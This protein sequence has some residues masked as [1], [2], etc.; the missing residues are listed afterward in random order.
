M[1]ERVVQSSELGL[2]EACHLMPRCFKQT[3]PDENDSFTHLRLSHHLSFTLLSAFSSCENL[4]D[5]VTPILLLLLL[6][7]LHPLSP[8][9]SP[10]SF[11]LPLLR[12]GD[13]D[14]FDRRTPPKLLHHNSPPFCH[15]PTYTPLSQFLPTLPSLG[16][17]Q[18][19]LF[20]RRWF[21]REYQC[22]TVSECRARWTEPFPAVSNRC[23]LL[24]PL[25]LLLLLLPLLLLHHWC[26][27]Q[28]LRPRHWPPARAS[29]QTQ[30]QAEPTSPNNVVSFESCGYTAYIKG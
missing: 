5:T 17:W 11:T 30:K 24:L 8:F 27:R 14:P 6:L 10:P 19:G 23:P 2:A 22:A 16:V 18:V 25:L 12:P 9:S 29:A 3:Q 13:C 20:S 1:T 26:P 21:S 15:P 7:L 4:S 28:P